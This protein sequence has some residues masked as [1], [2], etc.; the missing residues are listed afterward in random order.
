MPIAPDFHSDV[1]SYSPS[2]Q[3]M[4]RGSANRAKSSPCGHS[5]S[6]RAVTS[7]SELKEC[8]QNINPPQV[9]MPAESLSNQAKREVKSVCEEVVHALRERLPVSNDP[10]VTTCVP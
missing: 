3:K 9:R 10:R 2:W 4:A 7:A 8:L 5:N 6:K 1:V